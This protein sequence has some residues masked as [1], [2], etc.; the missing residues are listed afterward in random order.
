MKFE[1]ISSFIKEHFYTVVQFITMNYRTEAHC[2]TAEELY[3]VWLE[4]GLLLINQTIIHQVT[5][6]S[7]GNAYPV[8]MNTRDERTFEELMRQMEIGIKAR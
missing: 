6:Y 1:D 8:I 3:T 4:G 7:G 5:L 2:N